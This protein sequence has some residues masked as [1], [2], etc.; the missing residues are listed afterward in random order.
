MAATDAFREIGSRSFWII[1]TSKTRM[2]T[3]RKR[4]VISYP[5]SV[6]AVERQYGGWAVVSQ[7]AWIGR[8][9]NTMTDVTMMNQ[10]KQNPLVTITVLVKFVLMEKI[11]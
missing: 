9:W 11:Q 2:V 3:S 1:P 5:S 8:H 6:L 7:N 10:V 4:L